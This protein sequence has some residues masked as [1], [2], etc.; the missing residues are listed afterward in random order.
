MMPGARAFG[1]LDPY[2]FALAALLRDMA[3]D[4]R[5]RDAARDQLLERRIGDL[6]ESRSLRL[7]R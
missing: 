5:F 6:L 7:R 1:S 4:N 3:R 2:A